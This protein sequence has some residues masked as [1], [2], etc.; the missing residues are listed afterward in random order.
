MKEHTKHQM[1]AIVI[2]Q[3]ERLISHAKEELNLSP[4]NFEIKYYYQL[5][6]KEI[7][8]LAV[9]LGLLSTRKKNQYEHAAAE[10]LGKC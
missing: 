1:T 8:V 10:E 5:L 6:I 9:D 3:Y 7:L 4:G 2:K